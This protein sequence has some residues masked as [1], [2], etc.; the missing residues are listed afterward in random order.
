MT[1]GKGPHG[2][3]KKD[4]KSKPVKANQALLTKGLKTGS[5]PSSK[6]AAAS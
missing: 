3:T 1:N 4:A 5:A 6:K 2:P